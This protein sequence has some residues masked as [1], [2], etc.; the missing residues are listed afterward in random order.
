MRLTRR[1]LRKLINEEVFRTGNRKIIRESKG[2][3]MT[4]APE[5]LKDFA[6]EVFAAVHAMGAKPDR[7]DNVV[8]RRNDKT[9]KLDREVIGDEEVMTVSVTLPSDD[10]KSFGVAKKL[11]ALGYGVEAA[12]IFNQLVDSMKNKVILKVSE[13]D[14]K[15]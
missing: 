14:Y 7:Y 2:W 1:Q 11:R 13:V 6:V 8:N 12:P 3:N 15:D 9:V 5:D 10:E 4:S